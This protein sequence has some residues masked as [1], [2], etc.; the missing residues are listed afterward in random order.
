MNR[1]GVC[2]EI[3]IATCW[4]SAAPAALAGGF[5]Y[6]GALTDRGHAANGY[7]DFQ[8]TTYA[9]GKSRDP[10]LAPI[11]FEHV[12]V[13]EGRFQLEFELAS[14]DTDALWVELAVRDPGANS[15]SR[16]PERTKAIATPLIGQCWST[17][18]D[19]GSNPASDFLGTIDN[20]PL[21]LR[22]RN[23]QSLRLEPGPLHSDGLPFTANVVAGF[24]LNSLE[25]DV[26]G[27]TIAG[28]G[29]TPGADA[30]ISLSVG[31]PN[32]ITDAYG[33]V[34][35]GY[36]NVAGDDNG[37]GGFVGSAQHATVSGGRDNRAAS[38]DAAIGGGSAN[39]V[40][41][42]AG[43]VSGGRQ[44]QSS[45]SD[46]S[47]S[48]G[49]TNTASGRA[50]AVLGGENNCAGGEYSSAHGRRSKVRPGSNSGNAGNG[51]NGIALSGDVNGDEG[52][53]VW[54][55]AQNQD[56]ISTGP[57]QWLARAEGGIVMQK[58]IAAETSARKPRGFFNVVTGDSGIAQPASPSAT[59]MA[60]FEN[61]SD[62]FIS[63]LGPAN[64]NLGLVFGSPSSTSQGGLVYIGAAD[65]L[66]FFAGGNAR[67]TLTGTGQLVLPTLGTAGATSLCRNASNQI[68]SCSSSARYKDHIEDLRLGLDAALLLRPVG[69]QW[70]DTHVADVGFV[71]EEVATLDERLVTRNAEGEIEGVKYDRLTVVLAGAVQELAARE[72]LQSESISRLDAENAAIRAELDDMRR[73]IHSLRREER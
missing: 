38:S 41:A 37:P 71:A 15:F 67:M 30:G 49:N 62:A 55:D 6:D 2:C 56:F 70:K 17:S 46:S 39:V 13:D 65:Q 4:L 50:A 72:Q 28:G 7:Y 68:A 32:R 5:S 42:F 12:S 52:T 33:T 29:K 18:G 58:R 3:L 25:T 27:A 24:R 23:V 35:G 66:Q 21:V 40:T 8:L 9:S 26:R 73:M 16:L 61:N 1:R 11:V 44:N 45:G 64:V 14:T 53:S 60:S 22:T 57:N 34:G 69:Y 31:G 63:L 48:G 51:C 10:L 43:V 59:L 47:I 19:S 36:N 54:A 20:Q